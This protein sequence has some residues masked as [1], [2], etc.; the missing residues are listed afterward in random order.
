MKQNTTFIGL[1]L[2][3]NTDQDILQALEAKQK[4]LQFTKAD[5]NRVTGERFRALKKFPI[6]IDKKGKIC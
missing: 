1:K 5:L 4:K 6:F 3:N 2:N